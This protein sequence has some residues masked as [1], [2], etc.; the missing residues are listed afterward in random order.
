MPV[1]R[2]A[3]LVKMHLTRLLLLGASLGLALPVTIHAQD[4]PGSTDWLVEEI[5]ITARKREEGLQSTPLSVSAYSGDSLEYRGV[6]KIDGIANFTPNLTFG[7]SPTFGGAS[8]SA[9]IY[10]RGIGQKEFVPTVDP[11][12]GLYVDGVYIARSVGGILDLIDIERVEVLRGPQG[13]L[14]GRNTIGGAISITTRKPDEEL[15]GRLSATYG[16]D[17]RIDVIGSVNVPWSDSFFSTFS[18]GHL[19]QDGYVKRDDGVDLGDENTLTGRAAF[20]WLASEA[21]A[22]HLSLEGTRAPENSPAL[23]LIDIYQ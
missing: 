3:P 7:N 9:A 6:G 12:V 19:S 2:R 14:F 22:V 23:K 20:R 4:K 17:N 16:V 10:I 11:G 1:S 18:V 15:S 5:T 13:T 8:N 21:V